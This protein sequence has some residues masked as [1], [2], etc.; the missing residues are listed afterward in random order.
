MI[1][2]HE[3]ILTIESDI[4]HNNMINIHYSAGFTYEESAILSWVSREEATSP[5]TRQPL[6]PGMTKDV[7][8]EKLVELYNAIVK[9]QQ[10]QSTTPPLNS[11][12]GSAGANAEKGGA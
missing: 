11:T 2:T 10:Q 12:Q 3:K 7:E 5:L 8:M 4:L 1:G 9:S 6:Q